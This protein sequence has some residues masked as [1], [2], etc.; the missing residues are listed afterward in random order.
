MFDVS[1]VPSFILSLLFSFLFDFALAFAFES[2]TPL[3]SR[4]GQSDIS[5]PL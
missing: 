3:Q 2:F 5:A 1:D 4:R